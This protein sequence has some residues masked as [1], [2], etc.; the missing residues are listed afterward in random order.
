MHVKR[1]RFNEQ[2]AFKRSNRFLLELTFPFYTMQTKAI[3][4]LKTKTTHRQGIIPWTQGC[5]FT[6]LVL[7]DL[8]RPDKHEYETSD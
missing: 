8:L 1:W 6:V 3:T 7:F 4:N 2:E 5:C